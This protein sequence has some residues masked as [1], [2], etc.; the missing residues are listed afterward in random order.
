MTKTNKIVLCIVLASVLMLAVFSAVLPMQTAKAEGDIYKLVTDVSELKA[1]DSIIIVAS[2]SDVALSTTQNSNNRGTTAVTKDTTNNTIVPGSEVQIITLESG[3]TS[4]T[5][6]FNVGEGGYLYCAST[7]S[8]N[9]LKVE[10]AVTEKSS[11]KITITDGIA[12]IKS[13]VSGINRNIMSYNASNSVFACYSSIQSKGDLSIYKKVEASACTHASKEHLEAVAA[14]CEKS[15]ILKDCYHC[16]TE[17]GCNGYFSDEACTNQLAEADVIAP[18]TGHSW[19]EGTETTPATCSTKGVKTYTCTL[20]KQTKE[21]AIETTDHNW[22]DWTVTKEANCSDGE[23]TRTCSVCSATEKQTIKAT[24][25]H[26]YVNG[27]CS[28]CG[29]EQPIVRRFDKV[30]TAP[31]D[32]SGEYIIVYES[33]ATASVFTGVDAASNYVAGTIVEV[34]GNKTI[35]ETTTDEFTVATIAKMEDGSYSIYINGKYI[36]GTSGKN[37][38]NTAAAASSNTIELATDGSATITSNTSVLRFYTG[39]GAR[40][41]YYKSDS[42]TKQEAI[43]LYKRYVN[44]TCAHT[45]KKTEA[46][47][48]A[49]CM[50]SGKVDVWTCIDCGYVSEGTE[51]A[52][53][54]H[55]YTGTDGKCVNGCDCTKEV[56]DLLDEIFALTTGSFLSESDGTN[57]T[58]TLTGKIVK[59][60]EAYSAKY[61]NITVTMQVG[62]WATR[63][64]QCYR[65][66]YGKNRAVGDTLTVYGAVQNNAGTYRFASGA[67]PNHLVDKAVKTDYKAHT[68]TE[69]GNIEYWTCP[70]CGKNFSDAALTA[71]VKSTVIS[72]GHAV[73]LVAVA[74]KDPTCSEEGT[75]AYWYCSACNQK[76]SDAEGLTAI[77]NA[78]TIEK[79]P[80]T[81]DGGKVE[82]E[83]AC[84]TA[85][86]TRYTCTVCNYSYTKDIAAK[87]HTT[88]H[89]EEKDASCTEDGNFEYWT[90]SVCKK[91]YSDS[92][93]TEEV[94]LADVTVEKYNHEGK[95]HTEAAEAKCGVAGTKEYWYCNLCKKYFTNEECTNSV[96]KETLVVAALEH[97]WDEG[98]VDTAPTCTD[99]GL[100]VYHCT[101]TGCDGQDVKEI[102]ALGHDYTV[103]EAV[104]NLTGELSCTK[105]KTCSHDASH[106]VTETATIENG[107]LEKKVTQV[108]SC[109]NDEISTLKA[110]FTDAELGS[111]T[112]ENVA[113]ANATGAHVYGT[114]VEVVKAATC[115][116]AGQEKYKCNGCDETT[117]KDTS[118]L[119]HDMD[120][121][122]ITTKATCTT[123]GVKTFSCNREGCDHTTTEVVTKTGHNFGEWTVT[124]PATCTAKGV[125]TRT[126]SNEGCTESETREIAM[127]SHS[128]DN[129]FACKDKT[130]T[131]CGNV[132]KA[133][134]EHKWNDGVVEKEPSA[135]EE[136][137]KAHTC[138]VCGEVKYETIPATGKTGCKSVVSTSAVA[139]LIIGLGLAVSVVVKRSKKQ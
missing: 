30:T 53:L 85:G 110:T 132:E 75:E 3:V 66:L 48:V 128:Y 56:N 114:F 70:D 52:K 9:Y 8:K 125:E 5:F 98:T 127:V 113:T 131:V 59:I 32:W 79:I 93:Y 82:L 57:R 43:Y 60:D 91:I 81:Y 112:K 137:K 22:S 49:T 133:T 37:I 23:Q 65:M 88:T 17:N 39:S 118:A 27:I 96:E 35:T 6:A 94:T 28:V 62:N 77:A 121:G 92:A 51:V 1:G 68:C 14:T 109:K 134:A 116:E 18:A 34:D 135:K 103:G 55:S 36:S 20:C 102:E 46:D 47:V 4:G 136:G 101:R 12:L 107:K 21:E 41:R 120:E 117:T 58:I 13:T 73:P 71:E 19:D 86:R 129:N 104:W 72:H 69:D 80:H 61:N 15:G 106:V 26:N 64:I 95:T 138:E 108:L 78:V 24:G 76:F 87:G 10:S 139:T 31:T 122:K 89:T 124:T 50:A 83:P 54:E 44:T 25:E 11:W 100:K 33:E 7:S 45:N 29:K 126:C 38:I 63:Q 84:T 111:E 16:T 123:D 119:G 42:Y 74:K 67:T 105:T 40:F 90:C 115:T 2:A 130:C 97:V 99:I